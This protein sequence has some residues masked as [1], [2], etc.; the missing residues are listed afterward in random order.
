MIEVRDN[1]LY[2]DGNP[3]A[4]EQELMTIFE[5]AVKYDEVTAIFGGDSQWTNHLKVSKTY[6]FKMKH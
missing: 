4:N 1:I 5:K 2:R 6:Y 3:I